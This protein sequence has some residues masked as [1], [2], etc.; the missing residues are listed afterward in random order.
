[1]WP[2]IL[3]VAVRPIQGPGPRA[4][5]GT[6]LGP[7]EPAVLGATARLVPVRRWTPL[8]PRRVFSALSSRS[9]RPEKRTAGQDR[10]WHTKTH[11]AAW[12]GRRDQNLKSQASSL[13]PASAGKPQACF[14]LP[15]FP[16]EDQAQTAEAQQGEL[17]ELA[18]P[19]E[20]LGE[21]AHEA[22]PIE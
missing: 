3:A 13:K 12:E 19:Q 9:T 15:S 16:S 4:R 10:P 1:M 17:G 21:Q 18:P 6:R 14:A 2:R 11:A 20:E 7:I 8:G 5:C 22:Q